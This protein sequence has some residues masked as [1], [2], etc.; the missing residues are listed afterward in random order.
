MKSFHDLTRRAGIPKIS[1]P[2]EVCTVSVPS[3]YRFC[4]KTF[5]KK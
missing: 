3:L 2:L 4:T 5:L 1:R